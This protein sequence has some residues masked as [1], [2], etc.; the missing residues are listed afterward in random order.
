MPRL[1]RG[2]LSGVREPVRLARL[3][4]RGGGMMLPAAA[5]AWE[6]VRLAGRV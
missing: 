1:L 5:P 3:T 6:S 2:L 4:G